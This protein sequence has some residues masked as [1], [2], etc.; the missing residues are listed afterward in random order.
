MAE[1]S[2]MNAGDGVH[3]YAKNSQAQRILSSSVE[4]TINEIILQSLD[5]KGIITSSSTF[6][7]VDLGCSSGPNTFFSM[8]NIIEAV[9]SKY[10]S[11]ELNPKTLRFQV[12]FNDQTNNDFNTLFG[13]L[14]PNRQYF[15]AGVPGSF[16]GR[17]FPSSSIHVAYSSYALHWLSKVPEELLIKNSP[18]WNG[19]RIHYTGASNDVVN[20]YAAQFENDMDIFLRA[21]AEEIVP[22]GMVV[23]L[24]PGAMDEVPMNDVGMV[25]TFFGSILMEMV[26]EG[27]LNQDQVDTFNVPQVY[28]SVKEMTRLVEKNGLFNIEKM[29]L[30]NRKANI[31]AG[32][33]PESGIMHLRAVGEGTFAKHFGGHIVDE[34]FKR[35]VQQK[36]TL[37]HFLSVLSG[38][39]I[40]IQLFA[41]LK[42]K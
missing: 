41:V 2:P 7:I 15:V 19:G 11:Q 16:H 5:V 10:L 42:R 40:G 39:E 14:P 3:S 36:E 38:V 21:R 28:P 34:M 32:I 1:P 26:H 22:G 17:L 27:L 9:E 6:S 18:A 33:D 25:F 30:K 37:Y 8:Q 23:I 29:E 4:D 24:M 12:F 13:S 20:A 31:K 35:T